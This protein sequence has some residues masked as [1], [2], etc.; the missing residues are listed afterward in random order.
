M[1]A[2][3][4][5]LRKRSHSSPL[6]LF[7]NPTQR[8]GCHLGLQT[9]TSQLT[10]TRKFLSRAAFTFNFPKTCTYNNATSGVPLQKGDCSHPQRLCKKVLQEVLSGVGSK[11]GRGMLGTIFRLFPA[12]FKDATVSPALMP[13]LGPPTQLSPPSASQL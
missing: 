6:W 10:R 5:G 2:G 11:R 12:V 3:R 8:L 7:R 4:H 9:A 13:L 1:A